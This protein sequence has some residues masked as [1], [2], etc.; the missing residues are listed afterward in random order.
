MMLREENKQEE[1][2]RRE[3]NGEK[4]QDKK[5]KIFKRK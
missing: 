2:G 5:E 4:W 3:P 1:W